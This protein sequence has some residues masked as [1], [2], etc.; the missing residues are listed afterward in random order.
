MSTPTK[1][2][3]KSRRGFRSAHMK[4]KKPVFSVCSKCKKRVVPHTACSFCGYYKDK[5]VLKIKTKVSKKKT[6]KEK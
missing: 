6:N 5:Q 1:R 3:P 2:L 4:L